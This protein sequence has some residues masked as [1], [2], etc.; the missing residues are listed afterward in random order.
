MCVDCIYPGSQTHA[1]S[2]KNAV[3]GFTEVVSRMSRAMKKQREGSTRNRFRP[4]HSTS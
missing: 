2:V 3:M 1:S 4:T